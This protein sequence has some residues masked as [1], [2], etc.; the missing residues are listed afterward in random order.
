[1]KHP[2]QI[3]IP[4]GGLPRMHAEG[5]CLLCGRRFDARKLPVLLSRGGICSFCRMDILKITTPGRSDRASVEEEIAAQSNPN[6]LAVALANATGDW[7][8]SAIR[9][10][11]QALGSR[12]QGKVV[13]HRS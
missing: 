3:E 9:N 8:R 10:R 4:Q 7:R 11:Q 2:W 5:G 6:V 12:D 1:M 13:G